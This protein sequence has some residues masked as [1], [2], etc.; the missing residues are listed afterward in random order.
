MFAFLLLS[1][2]L[3]HKKLNFVGPPK[4]IHGPKLFQMLPLTFKNE[5]PCCH[6]LDLNPVLPVWLLLEPTGTL[7]RTAIAIP[8]EKC[9]A[10]SVRQGCLAGQYSQTLQGD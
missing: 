3:A 10:V 9:G 4:G 7:A 6:C 8:P 1:L 5:M 2:S